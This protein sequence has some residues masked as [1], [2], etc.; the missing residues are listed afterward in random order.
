M[1]FAVKVC[2]IIS[3]L[4][5]RLCF[6]QNLNVDEIDVLSQHKLIFLSQIKPK[7]FLLLGQLGLNINIFLEIIL[8]FSNVLALRKDDG[9]F[10][11]ENVVLEFDLVGFLRLFVVVIEENVLGFGTVAVKS[12][13]RDKVH[14]FWIV[15][16][17]EHVHGEKTVLFV[18]IVIFH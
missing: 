13:S 17:W 2:G 6:L 15:N 3:A 16:Q 12:H 14:G 5:E 18:N 7:Y 1:K 8:G 9:K 10:R 11:L 4:L